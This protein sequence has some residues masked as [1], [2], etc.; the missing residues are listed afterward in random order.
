M[1]ILKAVTLVTTVVLAVA[2]QG[3]AAGSVTTSDVVVGPKTDEPG[4]S[5][6]LVLTKGHKVSVSATG[7]LCP[8]GGA[9]CVGPDGDA[10]HDTKQSAFGGYVLP[11]A[12]AWGVVAR[13]GGGQ[14]VQVG[15]GPTKLSGIGELVF[16]VNDDLFGDNTGGFVVTVSYNESGVSRTCWPGWGW[17]DLNHVH[18]G[19]PGQ[20]NKTGQSSDQHRGSSDEHGKSEGN[21]NSKK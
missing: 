1:K 18:C 14:W 7:S 5:S 3:S 15:S 11:G 9:F 17:G 20:E 4:V 19:P 2:A 13:V 16:A 12:P 6:G 21:G 8:Y 10:S